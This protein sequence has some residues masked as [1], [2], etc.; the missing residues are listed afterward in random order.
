[1]KPNVLHIIDS[2][3]QGG[4][5]RQAVQLARL[6]HESARY[7]VHMACIHDQ[8]VL[9]PEVQRLGIGE[10]AAYPL[11]SFFNRNFARQLRRFRQFL[12]EREINIVHAHGLYTNVLGITGAALARVP[13]RIASRRETGGIRNNVQ[14]WG[15]RRVFGLAQVIIANA[16]AVRRELISEGVPPEK[17]EIVY[18]GLDLGRIAPQAGWSREETLSHLG[19]PPKSERR[20]V[21]IVANVN[22][23]VKDHPLFLRAARR[24]REA[25]SE[26][27]FVI[28]GEG[29]L[30]ESLRALAVELGIERDVFFIGR[31]ERVAELLEVSEVCVLS[32]KAEGFSNAIL[33][34]MAAARPVVATDVGGAREAILEGETGHLVAS[35]DDATMAERIISLLKNPERAQKMGERG[36]R[37]VEEKFSSEAQLERTEKLYDELLA[38]TSLGWTR[39]VETIGRFGRLN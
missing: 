39:S 15:E 36:R 35:G 34:Y 11:N 26:A 8:G 24:V 38:K 21:T 14:R 33:E 16:D 7:R 19:L 22:L 23:P 31:C 25:I 13:V 28:A 10:I 5:E 27:A 30:M 37:V 29:E 20:F 4:T 3:D 6:L 1:L 9:R 2:F 17:I 32:S 12:H 18:N